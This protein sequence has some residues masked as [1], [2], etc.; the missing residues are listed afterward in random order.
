MGRQAYGIVGGLVG[1]AVVGLATGGTATLQGYAAGF[2]L[3]SAVGGIAGSYIDPLVIQGNKV[4][5]NAIQVAAEGGARAIIYG[6]GCITSTCVIARGNR[7]VVKKKQ[8]NGKGSSGSTSNEYVYWTFAIG[9][10]EDIID[11][12]ITRIWQDENLV[13][14]TLGD[15]AIS[16]EDNEK[17]AAKFKFYDGNESQL[18]DPDL[19]V[20][21]G[22]DTPYFRGTA[23]V[24]FP[25]FDLTATAERIPQFKFEVV[26]GVDGFIDELESL[27]WD[28]QGLVG[29][30]TSQSVTLTSPVDMTLDVDLYFTGHMEARNY[31]DH[32]TRIGGGGRFITADSS[33]A[34]PTPFNIYKVVVSDP[35]QTY[36]LNCFLPGEIG[37]TIIFDMD[38]S[39][40]WKLS[41]T[42]KGNATISYICD[43]VDGTSATA[44]QF[45]QARAEITGRTVGGSGTVLLSTIVED[46][47][48]KTGMDSA[49][50]DTSALTDLTAGVVIQDTSTGADAIGAVVAAFFADPTEQDGKLVWNKRGG[51]VDRV[52]TIDDLVEEP[53]VSTRESVI[54]YPAKLHFY[55]QSP[56]TGYASTKATS[57]RYSPQ[58]DS[59]G[60]GSVQS[61][62]T[63]TDSD[64]PMQIAQKLHKQA[65][66]EATGSFTWKVGL[67]CIEL[68]PSSVVGLSLRGVVNRA[69][70]TAI[71]NDGQSLTLTMLNDRQSSY[72][73]A[74]TGIPLPLPTPPLPKTMSK[75]VLAVLDVPAL[76]DSDD[77]LGYYLAASGMTAVWQGCEIQRSLDGGASYTAIAQVTTEATMGRLTVAMTAADSEYTDT[78]NTVTVQLFD[79]GNDL[80]SYTEALFDSEQGSI[81]IQN[82]DGSWEVL[83]YRDAV[84]GGSGL[85]TLSTLKRGRLTTT[86]G[87]HAVGA[88][89]VKLDQYVIRQTAQVAWIGQT[90]KHRAVSYSTSSEDADV[91]STVYAGFSQLEWPP[92]SATV[93]WDG[94]SVA[95]RNIVPR[96]RFGTDD[97]PV[98]S[99]NFYGFRITASNGTQTVTS[100]TSTTNAFATMI[101]APTSVTIQ[102]LNKITGPGAALTVTD[103]ATVPAGSNTPEAVVN[104]GGGA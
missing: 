9:L 102:A 21:L 40:T 3:G 95:V 63:F 44:P 4:G 68:L 83:Q 62:V 2:A 22:D 52:L 72:T 99:T 85:W 6:R 67:H 91:V 13:Y 61:P 25:N 90:L 7:Q 79:S 5:D 59:S 16:D 12:S 73:S 75:A 27:R 49:D 32:I 93:T 54:E 42:M 65:W 53:E 46:L 18:P 94:S 10:G 17:F 30:G 45:G 86:A 56:A 81:A 96:Y 14:S 77:L 11:G 55:Y 100:D 33:T 71:E 64:W 43:T 48:L 23:Y 31:N 97:N 87:A 1:A 20:F 35:P 19:Q 34:S 8:S 39:D 103:I 69:R 26:K 50:F 88:L 92:A 74:V 29:P 78:T 70:V 89:F 15:G 98:P 80:E 37:P 101:A 24:V 76:Q 57:Y 47:L 60:E 38:G 41:C 58:A 82:N 36:Y 104:G 51:D 84:D 28:L 66:T